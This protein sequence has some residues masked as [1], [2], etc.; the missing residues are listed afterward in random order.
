MTK[1]EDFIRLA[2]ARSTPWWRPRSQSSCCVCGPSGCTDNQTL[3][4][5][6]KKWLWNK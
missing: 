1:K 2:P 3:S 4:W 5:D 6:I